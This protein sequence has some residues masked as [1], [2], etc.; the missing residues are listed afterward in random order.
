MRLRKLLEQLVDQVEKGLKAQSFNGKQFLSFFAD[1][2]D[3]KAHV[4]FF[5][6][7]F[8]YIDQVG[9]FILEDAD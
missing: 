3:A 9:L 5:Y 2:E 6:L 4:D 8:H 1:I 7:N